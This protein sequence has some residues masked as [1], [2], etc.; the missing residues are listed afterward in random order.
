M[1]IRTLAR[2]ARL[3]TAVGALLAILVAALPVRT[4]AAHPLGNFTINRYARLDLYENLLV[5]HYVL[6][7]AEIPTF[8]LKERIDTDG[9]EILT[10]VELDAF[11]PSFAGEVRDRMRLTENGGRLEIEVVEQ[12]AEVAEGQASLD[13]LRIG[14]VLR[15][16]PANAEAA[17][18]EFTDLNYADRAGW[19]EIVVRPSEG[20]EATI[21]PRF[22]VDLSDALRDYGGTTREAAPSDAGVRLTWSPGSGAAAPPALAP[23]RGGLRTANDGLGR[24]LDSDRSLGIIL[25]SLLAA[26]GFGALHALGPGHGKSVVAAYLV[27]SRGTPRH[28]LALGLTVTAT[29]TA[30]V[31]ALGFFTIAASDLFAPEEAF[32]Y[33]GVGSGALIVVMGASLFVSRLRSLRTDAEGEVDAGL[34]RHGLFGKQHSHMPGSEAAHPHPHDDHEHEHGHDHVAADRAAAPGVTWRSLLTLGVAGGLLPCP[35]ALVVMLAAISLGQVLFGMLLIVAF[36]AGL[37]GVLVAIGFAVVLGKHLSK[38]PALSAIAG[39]PLAG[40]LLAGLPI[41]SALAVTLAGVAITVQA[42]QQPGL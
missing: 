6:D 5:I 8:V 41:V 35:S 3:L 32:V 37:A 25:L 4:A 12:T 15:A 14:I 10:Q 39:Q 42:L 34:H 13:V 38:R 36:S 33:L 2:N 18:F 26:M 27:G 20:T 17:A 1:T 21:E 22:L 30:A 19:R 9:D 7:F 11:L 23:E 28:A 40:R 24:L 29:H 31:Y 16:T